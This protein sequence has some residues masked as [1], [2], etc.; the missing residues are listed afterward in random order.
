MEGM[1][2]LL[3]ESLDEIQNELD[4]VKSKKTELEQ[5][6]NIL[7]CISNYITSF[8]IEVDMMNIDDLSK[9]IF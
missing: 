5:D 4:T 2:K 1:N 7:S 3:N 9:Y 8:L 6:V